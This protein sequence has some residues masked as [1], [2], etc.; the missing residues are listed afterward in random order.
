MKK[1]VLSTMGAFFLTA[2]MISCNQPKETEVSPTTAKAG[3]EPKSVIDLMEKE[4][5]KK[6]F[7]K[8]LLLKSEDGKSEMLMRVASETQENLET[9]LSMHEFKFTSMLEKPEPINKNLVPD[10]VDKNLKITDESPDLSNAIHVIREILNVK[11][12]DGSIGYS[13]NVRNLPI[14]SSKNAKV[15]SGNYYYDE[16]ISD[17]NRP[18]GIEFTVNSDDI[19]LAM[20]YREDWY[21]PNWFK[22]YFG[23]PNTWTQIFAGKNYLWNG[24]YIWIPTIQTYPFGDVWKVKTKIHYYQ[25]FGG[26]NYT[27]RWLT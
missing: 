8:D 19:W 21:N 17:P 13:L 7:K 1:I 25:N 3:E 11:L 5:G 18:D 24:S 22:Y 9:Y 16:E 6:Y 10:K 2:V 26:R 4:R 20:D 27:R 15:N 12:S 23:Y 14:N